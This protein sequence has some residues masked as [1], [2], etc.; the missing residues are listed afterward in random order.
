MAGG[1]GQSIP[2]QYL[3]TTVL[4]QTT[5][6]QHTEGSNNS[7]L[8]CR[9]IG[10]MFA[11]RMIGLFGYACFIVYLIDIGMILVYCPLGGYFYDI[12]LLSTWRILV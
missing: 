8:L 3:F 2:E 1:V 6:L 12:G 5:R 4:Y 7:S 10:I 9:F 11:C